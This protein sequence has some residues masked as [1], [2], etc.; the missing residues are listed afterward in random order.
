MQQVLII[1]RKDVRHL[2][3]EILLVLATT[4]AFVWV[5]P[6]QWA[7]ETFQ[8]GR[9][10]HFDLRHLQILANIVTGCLPVAW[11]VLITR[12]VHSENL[13]GTRQFWLTRPYRWPQLLAAKLGFIVLCICLPFSA[14][15]A[16]LLVRGGF[17][18]SL[19]GGG[20]L[21]NLLLIVA[22]ILLPLFALSTVMSSLLRIV[23]LLIGLTAAVLVL[24]FFASMAHSYDEPSVSIPL[25]D[26]FSVPLLLAVCSTVL[27]L[28]YASRRLWL[29]RALLI[30]APVVIGLVAASPFE[31]HLMKHY[32]PA[33][34]PREPAPLALT[35]LTPA[36]R[37]VALGTLLIDDD[38]LTLLLPL[39]SSGIADSAALKMDNIQVTL[40]AP[41]GEQSVSPWQ[42]IYNHTLLPD[43][44]SDTLQANLDRGFVSR[45]SSELLTARIEVAFTEL[46]RETTRK[47]FLPSGNVFRVPDLGVCTYTPGLDQSFEA[48]HCRVPFHQPQLTYVEVYR[49]AGR[50]AGPLTIPT[51]ARLSS[52]WTGSLNPD[53]AD[54]GLT[55]VWTDDVSLA[56]EQIQGLS[57]PSVPLHLCPGSPVSFTRYD[58][59]RRFTYEFTQKDLQIPGKPNPTEPMTKEQRST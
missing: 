43:V 26:R 59:T 36:Q 14:A 2:W 3:P 11:L 17:R 4:A 33:L 25:A 28:Q 35:L 32:Y 38:H 50:C 24:A 5:Y 44:V 54:V 29:S 40:T 42:A 45:H 22:A 46:H 7:P 53:P 39:S 10:F 51:G 31:S 52:T 6:Y 37:G 30:I 55:P 15:Q 18:P 12:L 48:F 58:L 41:S 47:I 49:F 21:Y 9:G 27:I 56:S 34:A 13:V 57:G 23:G 8:S 1:F 19:H 20:L 16:A